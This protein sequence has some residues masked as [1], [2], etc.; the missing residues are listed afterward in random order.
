MA[1]DCPKQ[2]LHIAG[3]SIL[4][5]SVRAFL[6]QAAIA[7]VFV[8]VSADDAYAGSE[9]KPDARL[10]MLYCGGATRSDS[11]RNGLL[12]M[13]NQVGP[14]DWVMVHDAARPGINASLISR[15][16]EQTG[17]D[18]AGGLLAVPVADT[19]KLQT[20]TTI[21]TVPRAGL[22]LAQTPQMFRHAQ[23]LAALDHA[24]VNN[25]DITDEASAMEAA[26]YT[27][28]LVPGHWCNTKITRPDDLTLVESLM[29]KTVQ[30]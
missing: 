2:Y 18:T 30:S 7:H 20:A 17:N 1:A 5:H 23:L 6:D 12:A 27:P 3:K 29:T 25:V 14:D 13:Q 15:L 22:W 19:V 24:K 28:V 10:T 16:I 21:T 26:G 9:V 8:V 4:Q 11:V